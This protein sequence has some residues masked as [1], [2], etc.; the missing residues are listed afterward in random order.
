MNYYA[1]IAIG[2]VTDAALLLVL[3]ASPDTA[4][5]QGQATM[6]PITTPANLTITITKPNGGETI[7]TQQTYEITWQAQGVDRVWIS[8]VQGGKDHGLI[9]ENIPATT[10][11]YQ[12]K[13]PGDVSADF[14]TTGYKIFISNNSPNNEVRDESDETFSI[15]K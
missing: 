11:R 3:Y 9:A 10:G 12:W 4:Q 5:P 15:V 14:G 7:K 6:P 8:L 1:L 2:I 13:V